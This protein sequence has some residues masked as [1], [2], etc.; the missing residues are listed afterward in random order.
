MPDYNN[1]AA[2]VK[3]SLGRA[4]MAASYV[5]VTNGVY[6]PSTGSVTATEAT[7]QVSVVRLSYSEYEMNN[8][9]IKQGDIKVLMDATSLSEDPKTE[10]KIVMNSETWNII[11]IKPLDPAGIVVMYEL[12]LRK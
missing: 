4:G 10:D 12:R 11:D 5:S 6:N 3:A 8:T 9:Q 2:N 1:I 7:T